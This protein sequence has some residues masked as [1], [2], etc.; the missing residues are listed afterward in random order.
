MTKT[1]Q[2]SSQQKTPMTDN[3]T[4]KTVQPPEGVD[5]MNGA[6]FGSEN[7]SPPHPQYEALGM[8][9][10]HNK[11]VKERDELLEVNQ[12][13]RF[14]KEKAER[15]LLVEKKVVAA[16]EA[17]I[18]A[19]ELELASVRGFLRRIEDQ[20]RLQWIRE[21]PTS[22]ETTQR[23]FQSSAAHIG[24]QYRGFGEVMQK[25]DPDVGR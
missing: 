24:Q 6:D 3:K 25:R 10:A 19:L 11:A 13:L 21:N 4:D 18:R 8:I 20:E 12:N 7:V 1:S 5:F 9:A 2:Q 16:H 14:F 23:N 22:I 15:E 17:S